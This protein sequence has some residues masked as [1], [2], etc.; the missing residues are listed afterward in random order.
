MSSTMCRHMIL[1]AFLMHFIRHRVWP[2]ISL[3]ITLLPFLFSFF[4]IGIDKQV[5]CYTELL[6]LCGLYKV[7]GDQLDHLEAHSHSAGVALERLKAENLELKKSSNIMAIELAEARAQLSDS[8][9][10]WRLGM[11]ALI[12][13]GL[14]CAVQLSDLQLVWRTSMS[15]LIVMGLVCAVGFI[16]WRRAWR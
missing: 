2:H 1:Y 3:H 16:K 9:R 15:A 12:V 7:A 5:R 11:S 6:E 14:A 8:Q 4:N 13:M 10:M